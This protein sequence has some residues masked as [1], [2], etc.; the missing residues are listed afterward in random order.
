MSEERFPRLRMIDVEP[1]RQKKQNDGR[2]HRNDEFSDIVSI[3][4]N[5]CSQAYE[6]GRK[7]GVLVAADVI[8]IIVNRLREVQ[9]G[10]SLTV[11]EVISDAE[12]SI[13][14]LRNTIKRT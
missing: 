11:E 13:H 8:E 4:K 10:K 9:V 12:S 1:R 3:V 2:H 7:E 6:K 14:E 5:R